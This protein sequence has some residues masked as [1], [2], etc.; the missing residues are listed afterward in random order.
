MKMKSSTMRSK[1]IL[2][3]GFGILNSY[4]KYS[5]RVHIFKN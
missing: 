5:R 3:G 2:K 4:S 1:S